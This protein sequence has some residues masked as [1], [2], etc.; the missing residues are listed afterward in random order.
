MS[1]IGIIAVGGHYSMGHYVN[2][3]VIVDLLLQFFFSIQKHTCLYM[4]K[5]YLFNRTRSC[6]IDNSS[7]ETIFLKITGREDDPTIVF[8]TLYILPRDWCSDKS[9]MGPAK[10][11]T[12]YW[13]RYPSS[14]D[15]NKTES[16]LLGV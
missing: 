2:C 4:N 6:K 7:V 1:P 13:L 8:P 16:K 5:L 9:N 11:G 12:C 10:H 15:V 3:I 14:Q